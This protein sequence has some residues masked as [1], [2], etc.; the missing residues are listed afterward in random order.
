[1]YRTILG[2]AALLGSATALAQSVPP[3][4]ALAKAGAKG[5]AVY[6]VDPDG[7]RLTKIYQGRSNSRFGAPIDSIALR[8]RAEDSSGG[9]EVAFVEDLR[10]VKIQKHDSSGQPEGN[11]Y[12]VSVPAGSQCVFGDLDYLSNGT[13]V[14]SDS[15]GNVWS[16]APGYTTGASTPVIDGDNIN[17][18]TAIGD[19]I[20]YVDG[21]DLTR[22]T[23]A[24]ATS[25]LRTLENPFLFMDA[26]AATVFLS[27]RSTF[28]TVELSAPYGDLAGCTQGGMVEVSPDGSEM[29]YLYRNQLLLHASDC[30]GQTPTRVARGVRSFAWRTY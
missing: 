26:N 29:I 9:G 11:A 10:V 28:Q 21:S 3:P 19:D 5:D 13:L 17:S 20:L 1:M 16:V 30:S 8:L 22:R 4:I 25:T 15:C 23:S 14:V 6:L 18:L 24:G 2:I 7:G 27:D 12:E